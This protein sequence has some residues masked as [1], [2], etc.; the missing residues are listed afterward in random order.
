MHEVIRLIAEH[1]AEK[2]GLVTNLLPAFDRVTDNFT[3]FIAEQ[4]GGKPAGDF[5]LPGAQRRGENGLEPGLAGLAIA[6]AKRN[7]GESAFAAIVRRE[8]DERAAMLG[9]EA[10][11][12]F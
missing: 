8:V 2:F 1:R 6:S 9:R 11:V 7:A 4:I 12:N 5:E 3:V 10:R